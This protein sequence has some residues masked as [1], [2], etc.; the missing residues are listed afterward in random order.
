MLIIFQYS[1]HSHLAILL[2]LLAFANIFNI[3]T[4]KYFQYSMNLP[5]T[6]FNLV[7]NLPRTDLK[8]LGGWVVGG[9]VCKPILLIS[10]PVLVERNSD[11][12]SGLSW[13]V[14]GGGY[15]ILKISLCF[16]MLPLLLTL[17]NVFDIIRNACQSSLFF[18]QIF[19]E[20]EVIERSSCATTVQLWVIVVATL[21]LI[22]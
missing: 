12:F 8:V 5:I 9:W 15:W 19:R 16:P 18:S 6:I 2:I 13:E 17:A 20:N 11:I 7:Y 1:Q 21:G 3:P 14:P 4:W 10:L 22:L